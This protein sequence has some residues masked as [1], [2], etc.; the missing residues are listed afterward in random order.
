[1]HIN[2]FMSLVNASLLATGLLIPGLAAAPSICQ[3]AGGAN[4][5]PS[6][7]LSTLLAAAQDEEKRGAYVFYTQRFIDQQN[8]WASYEGSVFGSLTALKVNECEIKLEVVIQDIFTGTVGKKKTGRQIDTFKYSVSFTLTR[9]ITEGL[10]LELAPPSPLAANT[11]PTCSEKP[12]CSFEWLV[13]RAKQPVIWETRLLNDLQDA[14]DATDRFQ[15]PVST[16]EHGAAIIAGLK[17][18]AADRCP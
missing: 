1:M 2:P 5:E 10:S 13:V 4:A 18:L 7:A 9:E 12:S 8:Q 6:A 16:A 14:N 11:R 17:A 3:T 15:I